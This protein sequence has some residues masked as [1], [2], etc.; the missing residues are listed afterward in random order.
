MLILSIAIIYFIINKF[1]F[2]FMVRIRKLNEIK[3]SGNTAIGIIVDYKTCKNTG[4]IA[5]YLPIVE[6]FIND[7]SLRTIVDQPLREIPTIGS[8]ITV[9]FDEENSE[10]VIVNI[11]DAFINNFISLVFL[12]FIILLIIFF[13]IMKVMA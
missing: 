12:S 2:P 13:W 1:I 5:F 7:D 6:Y 10:N 4:D 11:R 8:Q 9:Y 3:K